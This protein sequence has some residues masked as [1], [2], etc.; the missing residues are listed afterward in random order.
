MGLRMPL[1]DPSELSFS[2]PGANHFD[3]IYSHHITSF[4][5]KS[6]HIRK[7]TEHTEEALGLWNREVVYQRERIHLALRRMYYNSEPGI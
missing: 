3:A 7:L 1:K 4:G 6:M 2:D 5:N